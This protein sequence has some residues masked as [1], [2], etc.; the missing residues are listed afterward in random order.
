MDK[1]IEKYFEQTINDEEKH[2]LNKMLAEDA[3]FRLEFEFYSEL[4]NAITISERE[5]IKK[6]VQALALPR[7]TP[8]FYL[9]RFL[10]YAAGLLLV[11]SAWI[12]LSTRSEDNEKLYLAYYEVYPNTEVSNTRNDFS[13]S[14]T[15]KDAFIAYDT[16]DYEEADRL[17]GL[18]QVESNTEYIRFY[19]A[20][21]LMELGSHKEALELFSDDNWS[22]SYRGKVLWFQALC[23]LKLGK[24]KEAK[25]ALEVLSNDYPFKTEEAKELLS[26][27]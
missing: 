16:E 18:A 27:L 4:K 20:V 3:D 15:I 5:K 1:L 14:S 13:Q 9:K 22:E 6:E 11:I 2:L 7:N 12:Y 21:S 23:Y 19:R 24:N 8:A 17:F 10:P 25:K 26:K